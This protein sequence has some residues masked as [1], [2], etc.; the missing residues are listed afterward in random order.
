MVD[1]ASASAGDCEPT[2]VGSGPAAQPHGQGA[3]RAAAAGR[4]GPQHRPAQPH[5]PRPGRR[6]N[7]RELGGA[8]TALGPDHDARSRPPP[9]ARPG[10]A[11][12]GR[13]VVGVQHEGERGAGDS[14]ATSAGRRQRRHVGRPG[15]PALLGRLPGGALPA[16]PR[17]RSARSP[18]QRVTSRSASHGTTA[19]TPSS[20]SQFDRELAAFALGQGLHDGRPT[21][22]GAGT[23]SRA[24][25][26][27]VTRRRRRSPPGRSAGCRA[28][29]RAAASRRAAPA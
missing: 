19:S 13:Q 22:R 4:G 27:S 20:V 25:T 16:W 11:A 23:S 26:V 12:A 18:F 21:G 15:P 10:P 14:S 17:P 2:G 28:R 6:S 24:S 3:A 1:R 29:R 9:A 8:D 5:Q 7:A